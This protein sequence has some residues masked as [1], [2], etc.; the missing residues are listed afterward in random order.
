M[1]QVDMLTQ[2]PRLAEAV[3]TRD[4]GTRRT[5]LGRAIRAHGKKPPLSGKS[6]E[7][8]TWLHLL[9]GYMD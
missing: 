8:S 7:A 9:R 3:E 5:D 4:R 1:S 2:S 6:N